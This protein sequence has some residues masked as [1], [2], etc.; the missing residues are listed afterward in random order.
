LRA[1]AGHPARLQITYGIDGR[2]R[3][4]E[5]E[6]P[7]LSGY[8]GSAPVPTGNAAADQL[9]LDV[10][11]EVLDGLALTRL[12]D[13]QSPDASWDLQVALMEH[14]EGAWQQP[15]NGPWEV[16]GPRRDCTHSKVMAWV[17]GRP[18]GRRRPALRAA[19]PGRPVGGTARHHPRQRPRP[20]LR[21]RPQHLHPVL[22]QPRARRQPAAPG[23]GRVGSLPHDD[24]RLAG[25]VEAVQRELTS[26]GLVL[27]YRPGA[28]RRRP[29]GRRRRVPGLL[30]LARRHVGRPGPQDR[31]PRPVRPAARPATTS[32]CS[33]SSTIRR[34]GGTWATRRRPSVTSR[35]SPA[36]WS[37]AAN[38]PRAA[39]RCPAP[40]QHDIWE[41]P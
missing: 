19:R 23:P 3:L 6:L 24:P 15:D 32:G 41:A 13:Q 11:G 10:W 26:D 36:P 8:Q 38:D 17:T 7:W 2:R 21:R 37:C 16:R 30:V 25:T 18:D 33:A 20:R 14:L 22:W 29:A 9:Q 35:W 40:D 39:T 31:R 27:R 4:P 1:V 12:A 28:L 34:P 5:T